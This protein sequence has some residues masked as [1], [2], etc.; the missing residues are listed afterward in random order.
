MAAPCNGLEIP[1]A[2]TVVIV[3]GYR[4]LS[5]W[6]PSILGFPVAAFL[7]RIRKRNQPEQEKLEPSP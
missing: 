1:H 4:L 6:I 3:L 2:T 5:F 7:E